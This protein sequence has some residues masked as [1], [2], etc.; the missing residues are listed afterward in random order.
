MKRKLL[1]LVAL[2]V[3]GIAVVAYLAPNASEG[4]PKVQ[5]SPPYVHSVIF[6]LNKDVPKGTLE[7]LVSDSH[8]LLAKIPSVRGLWA[9]RP[10]EKA[11]PKYAAT[12][13]QMG[14]L[15]LFDDYNGLKTYL[16]HDL[17]TQYV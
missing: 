12:D 17:H 15:V 7:T 16:D 3:A 9:G 6:Y 4:Q 2:V 10:A 11:T 14:L 5:N 8:K 1:S 13:Y